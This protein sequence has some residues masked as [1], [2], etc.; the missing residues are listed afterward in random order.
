MRGKDG[1]GNDGKRFHCITNNNTI[2]KQ[3]DTTYKTHM[4]DSSQYPVRM[5]TEVKVQL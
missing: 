3:I 5:S 1:N 4:A 2:L